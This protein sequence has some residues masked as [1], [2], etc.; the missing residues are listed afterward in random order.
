MP[1]YETVFISRQDISSAQVDTISDAM[2]EII[3]GDGGR[4]ARR[5]YWGLKSMAYRMKKNKKGHYVLF[6]YEA[7][8]A[9]VREMERQMGLNEDVLRLMTLRTDDLPEEPSVVMANRG[10]RGG[11]YERDRPRNDRDD[12]SDSNSSSSEGSGTARE[13]KGDSE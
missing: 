10:E 11:R 3:T 6:N 4:I 2:A 5:E 8:V 7:P 12:S 13:G 9:T 1:Y